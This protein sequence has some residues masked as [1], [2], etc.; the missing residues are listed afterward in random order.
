[1]DKLR[2]APTEH[3]ATDA[4]ATI[5]STVDGLD[6]AVGPA[7]AGQRRVGSQGASIAVD[8]AD[9]AHDR[10]DWAAAERRAAIDALFSELTRGL[11]RLVGHAA[12]R[13]AA[14]G[15]GLTA[16]RRAVT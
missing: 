16:R 5:W 11:L 8:L 3:A 2:N 13:V 9:L 15:R 4:G 7:G 14:A 10:S 12:D 1:M 6:I